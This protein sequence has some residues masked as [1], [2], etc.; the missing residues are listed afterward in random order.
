MKLP[1]VCSAYLAITHCQTLTN[2]LLAAIWAMSRLAVAAVTNRVSVDDVEIG[3]NLKFK[4][5]SSTQC[6]LE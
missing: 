6:I 2:S 4:L 5:V 3:S 1:N